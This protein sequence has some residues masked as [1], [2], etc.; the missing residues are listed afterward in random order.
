MLLQSLA[1]SLITR[2]IFLHPSQDLIQ[3]ISRQDAA[4]IVQ[5]QHVC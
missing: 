5:V 3:H 1:G 2:P 4:C